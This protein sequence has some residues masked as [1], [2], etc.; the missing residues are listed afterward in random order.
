[1]NWFNLK[2]KTKIVILVNVIV[3]LIGI[4]FT[5]YAYFNS[6]EISLSIGAGLVTSGIVA[7]FYLIYPHL[8]I[9][10]DYLHFRKMGLINVYQ[11]RDL[12]KEY[13][14]LLYKAEKQIDVLGLGLDHFRED[15]GDIIKAKA[16]EGVPVRLLVIKPDSQLSAIRSYQENDLGGETIEI[17]LKKLKIFVN[18]V[19]S[20][21]LHKIS[22]RNT[23]TYKI[24]AD[25]EIFKQYE[26]HFN[27][28]W[29]DARCT[30]NL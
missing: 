28:L 16:I 12:S 15:N 30:T 18:D 21:I 9:E 10:K 23:I 19:N 22:S 24:E 3:V 4:I 6:S 17:P 7:I 13:S 27:D 25:T 11:R 1:M 14:E 2:N 29:N 26:K 5:V 8:D 20:T